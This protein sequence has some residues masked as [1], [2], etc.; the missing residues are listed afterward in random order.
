MEVIS[1]PL[2]PTRR[3]RYLV[4]C[5]DRC[6]VRPG[7]PRRQETRERPKWRRSQRQGPAG[8]ARARRQLQLPDRVAELEATGAPPR[9]AQKPL[10]GGAP[11]EAAGES[12]R[13]R[14]EVEGYVQ[15]EGL[16]EKISS[17]TERA[18]GMSY[19]AV[20]V[21]LSGELPAR[22]H[23]LPRRTRERAVS[24]PN[25]RTG[26]PRRPRPPRSRGPGRPRKRILRASPP[27]APFRSP[28]NATKPRA[29]VS[30]SAKPSPSR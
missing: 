11:T 5:E 30:S 10:A 25:R 20:H 4:H 22:R 1:S 12:S 15:S 8:R 9:C 26:P 6:P 28:Q 21:G 29:R 23:P 3:A 13:P 14:F 2:P 16:G 27:S 18:A 19:L 7:G 17:A 24:S